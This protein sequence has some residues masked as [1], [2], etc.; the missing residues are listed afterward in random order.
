MRAWLTLAAAALL[1][2]CSSLPPAQPVSG[3]AARALRVGHG[4]PTIVLQ[5]GLGDGTAP[6]A[7]VFETL[8]REHQ[9]VA[10]ER[11]GYGGNPAGAAPRDP[12][13]IA[14]EQRALLQRLGIAP[15]Y[16]LV[17]HSLGGRY[18]WVYAALY[19]HEVAGLVLLE[20]THPEHWQRLRRD[21]PAMAAAVSALSL[22]FG[23]AMKREFDEQDRCLAERIGAA[24][25]AAV[26]RVPTR[27][28]ARE[29]Y[30]LAERGAFEAMHRQS[31]LDWLQL[32][33]APQVRRISG[34]GHYLQRDRPDAVVA[35]VR[36]MARAPVTRGAALRAPE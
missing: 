28:L 33:A 27:L 29:S 17:G 4:A 22:T 32:T 23:R 14:D 18:Q 20:P 15:P 9:V 7:A 34:S 2:A 35:A 1:A 30:P 6:W 24:Q 26:R 21:A 13:T 5:S 16:L 8:T 36:E 12:C 25:R 19:P 31:Q 11:P 3:V 10:L